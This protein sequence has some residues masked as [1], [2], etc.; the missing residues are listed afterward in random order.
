[1]SA[2][3][4]PSKSP[5]VLD[6][7]KND[8][9]LLAAPSPAAF[10]VSTD[11]VNE[12]RESGTSGVTEQVEVP[13]TAELYDCWMTGAPDEVWTDR[14]YDVA[15]LIALHVKV[16]AFVLILPLGDSSVVAGGGTVYDSAQP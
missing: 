6:P 9:L 16:G 1:M 4:S 2:F 7:T 13:H 10:R 11:H 12:P 5:G 14:T 8:R 15:E 3:A